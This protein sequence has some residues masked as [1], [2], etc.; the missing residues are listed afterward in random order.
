MRLSAEPVASL[1]EGLLSEEKQSSSGVMRGRR[2]S[3]APQ[4]RASLGREAIS[5]ASPWP[6][7]RRSPQRRASLGREAMTRPATCPDPVSWCL[8]EGRLSEEKQSIAEAADLVDVKPQRRASLGRE[9]ITRSGTCQCPAPSGLNEGLLSE[10]KQW[11]S[12]LWLRRRCAR[13]N[14]GLLSEE[15]QSA[16][17]R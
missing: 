8:N 14:E 11:R 12:R 5:N 7:S 1:N 13:L 2:S 6:P 4:R 16:P 15:K 10:E 17:R 3:S 9:A